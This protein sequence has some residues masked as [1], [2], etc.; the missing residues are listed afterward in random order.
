MGDSEGL[1]LLVLGK[2]EGG[3]GQEE[4]EAD[5]GEGEGV[6]VRGVGVGGLEVVLDYGG[7]KGGH[8]GVGWG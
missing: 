5:V 3:L 4:F 2:Q 8:V 1:E 6:V 7:V